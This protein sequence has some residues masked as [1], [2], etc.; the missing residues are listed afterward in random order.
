MFICCCCCRCCCCCCCC[1]FCF[2]FVCKCLLIWYRR[3]VQTWSSCM[4]VSLAGILTLCQFYW[5]SHCELF[6]KVF[7]YTEVSLF[8]GPLEKSNR[9][10]NRA[11]TACSSG[12]TDKGLQIHSFIWNVS[13]DTITVKLTPVVAQTRVYKMF[14]V[15]PL[16][17]SLFQWL[18]RQVSTDTFLPQVNNQIYS[19]G[20]DRAS[21]IL[22]LTDGQLGDLTESQLQVRSK[23]HHAYLHTNCTSSLFD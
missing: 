10:G 14:Q 1:C 5:P 2:L 12:C 17:W 21:V 8:P 11:K 18:H 20:G 15:T 23:P 9:P 6:A 22:I 7:S 16:R 3:S 19:L 4:P 13:L